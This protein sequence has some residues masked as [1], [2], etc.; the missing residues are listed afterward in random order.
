MVRLSP[1]F[2]LLHCNRPQ[3]ARR[4][5]QRAG[6]SRLILWLRD[7]AYHENGPDRHRGASFR[8]KPE[9]RDVSLSATFTLATKGAPAPMPSGGLR[10]N[11][12]GVVAP[13]IFALASDC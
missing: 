1:H 11:D 13:G 7:K 6:Q 10:R 8:R 3:P 4:M 5:W 9:P 12:E 2:L